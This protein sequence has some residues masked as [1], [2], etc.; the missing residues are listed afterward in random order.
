MFAGKGLYHVDAFKATLDGRVPENALLSHDLFEGLH[1]RAALVT[2][3]EVV[4]DFPATVLAHARRQRRWVR[5]DWQILWWLF[6][7]VPA[8]GGV[9]RNHLPLI[10]RWKILDNLRRSLLAPALLGLLVL[11][12][13]ILPGRPWFWTTLT[14][15]VL[16]TPV[17]LTLARLVTFP[18]LRQPLAVLLRRLAEDLETSFAQAIL[19]LMLLPYHAWEM[20][21]AIILTLIR[22]VITQ[23]RLLEWETAASVAVRLSTVEGRTALRTFIMEMAASPLIAIGILAMVAAV[24]PASLTVALPFIALWVAA[25]AV[26]YLL[27]R[28][29]AP[30]V[31]ILSAHDRRRLRQIARRTWHYFELFVG[32]ESHWLPPD[33]FQET[34]DGGLARRTSPTNIGMGL[35]STLAAHDLGFIDTGELVERIEAALD[36]IERLERHEGHLLNWYETHTLAALWPRYVSTVD[37]GNLVAALMALDVR[38]ARG[39]VRNDRTRRASRRPRRRRRAG[40]RIASR[41]RARVCRHAGALLR[42]CGRRRDRAAATGPGRRA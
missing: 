31:W 17:L 23:R 41:D 30:P 19:T 25:P 27:S 3:L 5:G 36:T 21:H 4:D 1:A 32:P 29:V 34:P 10:S 14:L 12:W 2:D 7:W 38:S 22:L 35:L 33:N 26:A 13:T 28:P 42:H 24:A 40:A 16:G 9:E 39:R 20:G 6:P 11:G 8:T 15:V 18:R 37:S